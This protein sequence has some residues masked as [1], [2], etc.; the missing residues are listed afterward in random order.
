MTAPPL[1]EAEPH[2]LALLALLATGLPPSITAA[3]GR[4]PLESAPPYV[5]L[6]P[7]AGDVVSARLAERHRRITVHVIVHA[8]GSGPE[9]AVWAGDKARA[10]LLGPAPAVAGR[11]TYPLVQTPGMPPL[12]RDDDVSPPLYM[13]VT[14]YEMRSDPA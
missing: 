7:D 5:V 2:V 14:E 1:P 8:I 11:H 12:S 6:Y 3:V 9:Q 4:A 13:A 10:V